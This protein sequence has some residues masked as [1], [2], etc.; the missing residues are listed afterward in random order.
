MKSRYILVGCLLVTTLAFK[1]AF[2][3]R[4]LDPLE[5]WCGLGIVGLI[6]AS[7]SPEGKRLGDKLADTRVQR[8]GV[9]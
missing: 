3:R 1:R 5:I 6:V 9:P 2:L 7:L 8:D 4:L